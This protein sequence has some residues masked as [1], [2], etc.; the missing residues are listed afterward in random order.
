LDHFRLRI[1][2]VIGYMLPGMAFLINIWILFIRNGNIFFYDKPGVNFSIN[3]VG[4]I[5][6][7]I[8]LSYIIGAILRIF[9]TDIPGKLSAGMR[10]IYKSIKILYI[11]SRMNNSL[12]KK[13]M[14]KYKS[15]KIIYERQ[16][17][18]RDYYHQPFPFVLWFRDDYLK[19]LPKEINKIYDELF[20]E[21]GLKNEQ[22]G[23]NNDSV[24]VSSKKAKD[25]FD[26]RTSGFNNFTRFF[27]YL[28]LQVINS[29]SQLGEEILFAE[30]LSRMTCGMVYSGFYSIL[31]ISIYAIVSY[32]SF[33]PA[34]LFINIIICLIFLWGVHHIRFKEVTTVYEAYAIIK[35]QNNTLKTSK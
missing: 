3:E 1:G 34:H 28:K 21:L 6:V 16:I 30:G 9:T 8:I 15:L 22:S 2:E 25:I 26:I 11:K 12:N 4:I 13:Q 27:N 20:T 7:F 10:I 29:S 18:I 31:I 33:N 5:V 14:E 35:I 23:A 32:A 17:E 24:N 19:S